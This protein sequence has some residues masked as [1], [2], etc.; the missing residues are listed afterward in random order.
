[1]S[2]LV[3]KTSCFCFVLNPLV[4][5]FIGTLLGVY[6]GYTFIA[7]VFSRYIQTIQSINTALI[8]IHLLQSTSFDSI[9]LYCNRKT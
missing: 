8:H 1:M 3:E 7:Q 4:T 9:V 2:L 6:L 5:L